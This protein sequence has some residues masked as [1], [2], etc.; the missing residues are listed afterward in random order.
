[1]AAQGE[2]PGPQRL[3]CLGGVGVGAAVVEPGERFLAQ[4]RGGGVK[5]RVEG[6]LE[7]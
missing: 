7:D 6:R 5:P 4:L 3:S 1:V 2:E